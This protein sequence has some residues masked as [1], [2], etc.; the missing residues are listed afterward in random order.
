[1]VVM[2]VVYC[3]GVSDCNLGP[4]QVAWS[5]LWWWPPPGRAQFMS[6]KWSWFASLTYRQCSVDSLWYVTSESKVKKVV[7]SVC[8]PNSFCLFES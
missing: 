8:G 7:C 1:M 3:G 5:C 6:A 2:V 4:F